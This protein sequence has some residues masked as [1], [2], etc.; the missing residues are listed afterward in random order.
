MREEAEKA[1][2]ELESAHQEA[3]AEAA[4][5][6][7]LAKVTIAEETAAKCHSEYEA[8]LLAEHESQTG[9]LATL[10]VEV[11]AL[12]AVLSHDTRYK[13]VSHATHQLTAALL[14]A[15][16]SPQPSTLATLPRL[17]AKIG[18][19]LLT[20]ALSPLAA[21]GG[22]ERYAKAPTHLQLAKRLETVAAAGRVAALVPE[23]APG[24][25]GHAL[26]AVTSSVTLH[27]AEEGHTTAS[28]A[29][30]KA[31]KAIE[32][33]DL[34]SAVVAMRTLSGPP[35]AAARGWLGAAEERLH[36]DQML[37]VATAASTV[38]TESLAPF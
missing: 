15:K 30:T 21:K 29:F 11:G 22:A 16:A 33:G 28:L 27:A 8:A 19:E 34:K 17:A 14:T 7:E 26:A 4:S 2:A 12:Q 1:L 31:E 32:R 35:A 3:L 13:E 6:M 18:D 24:L 10:S 20:E 23:N 38:A 9:R 37:M 5:A 36:L 25:W